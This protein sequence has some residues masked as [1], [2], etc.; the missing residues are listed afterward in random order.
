VRRRYLT[1]SELATYLGRSRRAI[2]HRVQRRGIPFIREGH[3]VMFDKL[4]IDRWMAESSV[5][6]GEFRQ[7]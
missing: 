4:A 1:V 7:Q 3:R 5:N 6:G 2:Y